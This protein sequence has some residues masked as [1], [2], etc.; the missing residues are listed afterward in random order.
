MRTI[1]YCL[2]LLAATG[3]GASASPVSTF[4]LVVDSQGQASTAAG[5]VHPGQLLPAAAELSVPAGGAQVD[6][7]FTGDKTYP[8]SDSSPGVSSGPET[9]VRVEAG[10]SLSLSRMEATDTGDGSL[11]QIQL[12]LASGSVL[13]V[14]RKLPAFSS[15]LILTPAGRVSIS[16]GTVE[17]SAD[18]VS[19][20]TGRAEFYPREAAGKT[21]MPLVLTSG[22]SYDNTAKAVSLLSPAAISALKQDAAGLYSLGPVHLSCGDDFTEDHL[23][24]IHPGHHHHHHHHHHRPDPG[25]DFDNIADDAGGD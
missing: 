25:D 10:S 9:M 2:F 15:F 21:S 3:A 8:S 13:V 19:V 24:P 12:Q 22:Q 18:G 7:Q 17:V 6:L 4:A 16:K 20:V 14:A 5:A 1:L 23:S 11:H